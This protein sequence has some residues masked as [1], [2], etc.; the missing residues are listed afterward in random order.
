M[1]MS[2]LAEVAHIAGVSSA[3]ASRVLNGSFRTPGED[4]SAR[5]QRAAESIGYVPNAQAQALATS[6]S[7]LVGLI[8]HDIAAP[9]F[10]TIAC[11]VQAAARDE[12]K[13]VLL[14]TTD[15]T[16]DSEREA[17][18]AFVGRR[19]DAIVVAGS[20]TIG[21]KAAHANAELAKDLD[22]YCNNGGRVGVIG[23]PIIGATATSGYHLVEV[24][25][26]TLATELA[27]ELALEGP[28]N[29]VIM[30]GPDGLLTSDDRV[31]G[32]QRGLA[33]AGLPRADV[34]RASFNR[35]GGYSTG[36][37]LASGL[38]PDTA[39]RD[40]APLT[41]LAANDMMAIGAVAAL[42]SAGPLIP[43]PRVAGFD[44]IELL[45]DFPPGLSTVRLPLAE[46]GRLAIAEAL[47]GNPSPVAV[48]GKII[49]R[50]SP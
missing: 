5:V 28:R 21:V 39:R 41:V 9:Y 34:V 48:A 11:G 8:V 7:G 38:R 45:R 31:R 14:A 46:I 49:L 22:R 50:G 37:R 20:R 1:T 4:I 40:G 18:A 23:H 16:P 19:A 2:T 44:D 17:V 24:P 26:E 25:N 33:A 15:G 36:L 29:F 35:A 43:Q 42:R 32:F 47:A 3:T 13:I 12:G 10:S 6:T 30:A 27:Q